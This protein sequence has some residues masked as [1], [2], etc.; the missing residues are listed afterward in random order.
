MMSHDSGSLITQ[1]T[2]TPSNE[3]KEH[4]NDESKKPI[5]NKT[6]LIHLPCNN[7]C[8]FDSACL[9][10]PAWKRFRTC[11][12]MKHPLVVRP[13]SKA[14][15]MHLF[16]QRVRKVFLSRRGVQ[17]CYEWLVTLLWGPVM[18]VIWSI[19]SHGCSHAL[20]H[21]Q[22][23]FI[24]IPILNTSSTWLALILPIYINMTAFHQSFINT[25]PLPLREDPQGRWPSQRASP[26][27]QAAARWESKSCSMAS[28]WW[29]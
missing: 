28:A 7:L 14:L 6:A 27:R 19:Y 8:L 23:I 16:S 24:L 25:D 15:F 10:R 22:G 26:W 21:N 18:L 20:S 1:Y 4:S 29:I 5:N 17:W 11:A 9:H 3:T 13:W 2:I 12:G